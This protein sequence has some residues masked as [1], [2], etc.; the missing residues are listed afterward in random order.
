M[1]KELIYHKNKSKENF[2]YIA[3]FL[4][5]LSLVSGPFIPD[6]IVVLICIFSIFFYFKKYKKNLFFNNFIKIL[7]IFYVYIFLNSFF[8]SEKFLSLKS[9]IPFLR[10]IIFAATISF[11]IQFKKI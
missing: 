8:S 10:F 5:I 6:L 4:F 1:F 2:L 7:L 11:L 3:T 9:S